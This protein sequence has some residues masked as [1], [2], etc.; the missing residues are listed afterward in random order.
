M[1]ETTNSPT[2]RSRLPQTKA[3]MALGAAGIALVLGAAGCSTGSPAGPAS[4][5]KMSTDTINTVLTSDP[6]TF[7]PAAVQNNDDYTVNRLLFDTLVRRDANNKIVGDLATDWKVTPTQGIFTIR[8]GSTCSDGTPVTAEVVANSLKHFAAPETKSNFRNLTFGT[9]TAAISSDAAAGTVTINLSQP[10]TDLLQGMSLHASGIVCPAGLKDPK[11]L[12]TGDAPGAFSGPF[13]LAKH[14]HGV[15]YTFSLRQ[16]YDAWPKYA[17]ALSGALPATINAAV[18]ANSSS[19]ANQLLTGTV[20]I[21]NLTTKDMD[22]FKADQGYGTAKFPIASYYVMFNERPGHPFTDTTL[23]QSVAKAIRQQAFN[24]AASGGLGEL[25]TSFASPGVPCANTDASILIKENTVEAKPKLTGLKVNMEGAQ[26]FGP[27][28]AANTYVSE[29]LRAAGADVKLNNVDVA[30]WSTDLT[31][32]PDSWDITV[33]A[34]IN[35][36]GTMNGALSTMVGTPAEKGGLNW[37]GAENSAV[38]GLSEKAMTQT[39]ESQRCGT[40]QQAQQIMIS[41]A[42][43][44]PMSSMPAQATTR[45]GFSMQV[46]NGQ[47]DASTMR[48]TK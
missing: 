25:Y 17:T 16:D 8:K 34:A 40:F 24:Q 6:T 2:W 21:A 9:G 39:D 22:R 48:I 7:D 46:L 18:N 5:A 42:H 32:K 19:V 27:N 14:E 35:A 1:P 38:V 4:A 45:S 44:V 12:K 23:R 41:D 43:A 37:G 30:T 28:G 10:W 33:M 29:A 13:T 47:A 26:V 11:A 20:D 31:Q 36:G 15:K 3:G